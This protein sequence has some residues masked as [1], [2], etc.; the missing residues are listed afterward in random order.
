MPTVTRSAKKAAASADP[1][2]PQKTP[3]KPAVKREAKSTTRRTPDTQRA[4]AE[5][6]GLRNETKSAKKKV[7]WDLSL[8]QKMEQQSRRLQR[9]RLGGTKLTEVPVTSLSL[10]NHGPFS[11]VLP[12][13]PTPESTTEK[14]REPDQRLVNQMLGTGSPG[15]MSR[16]RTAVHGYVYAG[17]QL[18]VFITFAI[19]WMLS[20]GTLRLTDFWK[21]WAYRYPPT[22][23]GWDL[24]GIRPWI[25]QNVRERNPVDV[26]QRVWWNPSTGH[27]ET[28]TYTR[29]TDPGIYRDRWPGETDG[30]DPEEFGKY[31]YLSQEDLL[32]KWLGEQIVKPLIRI[33]QF[34]VTVWVL[35]FSGIVII[36]VGHMYLAEFAEWVGEAIE[37]SPEL[38]EW[39]RNAWENTGGLVGKIW[40]MCKITGTD[41]KRCWE[42]YFYAEGS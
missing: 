41:A 28:V 17:K 12:R 1:V 16:F 15:I 10:K 23:D 34:C 14:F 36:S 4:P 19:C 8:E 24:F 38:E 37:S 21:R 27:Y 6:S 5:K 32:V 39:A 26:K 20:F 11:L 42:D 2:E 35:S 9:A 30:I 33:F 29:L 31:H 40:D 18:A 25:D 13:S 7:K 3:T 22:P